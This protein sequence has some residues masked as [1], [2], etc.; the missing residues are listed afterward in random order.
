[1][2]CFQFYI[3]AA[4]KVQETTWL[5]GSDEMKADAII[6]MSAIGSLGELMNGCVSTIKNL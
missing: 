3:F 5:A 1:V 2:N 4:N 6:K